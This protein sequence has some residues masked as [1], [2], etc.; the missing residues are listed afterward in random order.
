MDLKTKIV[1]WKHMQGNL[2]YLKLSK[3]YV[4]S[5]NLD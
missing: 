3:I 1:Q 2:L 4:V 5:F